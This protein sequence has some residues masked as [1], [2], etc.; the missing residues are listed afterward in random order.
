MTNF[1]LIGEINQILERIDKKLEDVQSDSHEGVSVKIAKLNS[2]PIEKF[3]R[4]KTT[5][6]SSQA[7]LSKYPKD[8]KKAKVQIKKYSFQPAICKKSLSIAE[9]LK[10][11]KTRLLINPEKKSQSPNFAFK[12]KINE[13]SEKILKKLKKSKKSA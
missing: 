7:V 4:L 6:S 11:S 10:N 1:Q 8:Y 5:G 13:K 3:S 9:N 2:D 12:P